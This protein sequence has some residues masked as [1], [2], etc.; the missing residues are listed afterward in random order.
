[1]KRGGLLIYA[2]CSLESEENS[3]LVNEF[4]ARHSEFARAPAMNAVAAE[5][6]TPD[7]DFRTLPQRHGVDGAYAAR[8]ERAR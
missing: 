5:L 7:G 8:L 6:L 1:V 3:D 4:L 2:T